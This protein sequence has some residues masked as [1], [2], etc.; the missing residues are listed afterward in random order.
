MYFGV[1]ASSGGHTS[2]EGP[3]AG[4]IFDFREA[5]LPH[6][7]DEV[8]LF[9]AVIL[10]LGLLELVLTGLITLDKYHASRRKED[11]SSRASTIPTEGAPENAR[12][13]QYPQPHPP[14]PTGLVSGLTPGLD[15]E[16][17]P[18]TSSTAGLRS[19]TVSVPLAAGNIEQIHLGGPAS[20]PSPETG[21][22]TLVD[23]ETHATL[24]RPR[25][26]L[27]RL[28][29][30]LLVG[31][32]DLI[33]LF[34]ANESLMT[35]LVGFVAYVLLLQFDDNIAN[36]FRLSIVGF[37]IILLP[38][39]IFNSGLEVNLGYFWRN[40][41]TILLFALVGTL[42]STMVL[43]GL[44][45]LGTLFVPDT[46]LDPYVALVFGAVISAV[47]P[48]AVL[49]VFAH[50]RVNETLYS[51]VFGESLLNDA[52]AIVLFELMLGFAE[53][54]PNVTNVGEGFLLLLIGLVQFVFVAV[55]GTIVGVVFGLLLALVSKYFKL[56]GLSASTTLLV[57]IV[58]E[59]AFLVAF[60]LRMSGIVAIFSFTIIVHRYLLVNLDDNHEMILKFIAVQA[61]SLADSVIFLFLGVELAVL[62]LPE[63]FTRASLSHTG[64]QVSFGFVGWMIFSIQL[65]RG[66]LIPL[67]ASLTNMTRELRITV[68]D[69]ALLVLAGL[70]GGIAVLLSLLIPSDL[71]GA[72]LVR[73]TTQFVTLFT[74]LVQGTLIGPLIKLLH[75]ER[76]QQARLEEAINQRDIRTHSSPDTSDDEREP[77][78]ATHERS[79]GEDLVSPPVL[80]TRDV[81]KLPS[82][83]KFTKEELTTLASLVEELFVYNRIVKD[84]A[85][86]LHRR[87]SQIIRW[88]QRLDLF[89]RTFLTA[90]F[91]GRTL[92]MIA[93]DP[94]DDILAGYTFLPQ[95]APDLAAGE[96]SLA[97]SEVES[98]DM[99]DI[100]PRPDT[101][102]SLRP[103]LGPRSPRRHRVQDAGRSALEIVHPGTFHSR[104]HRAGIRTW[105]GGQAPSLALR[106][107]QAGRLVGAQQHLLTSE[108][109]LL[110][111]MRVAGL[112][113]HVGGRD[114]TDSSLGPHQLKAASGLLRSQRSDIT[115]AQLKSAVGGRL[116][117][118]RS[119]RGLQATS[120]THQAFTSKQFQQFQSRHS[121]LPAGPT[122]MP[123]AS[124]PEVP[125]DLPLPPSP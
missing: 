113:S 121:D 11:S 51:L 10:M 37:E 67:L 84:V 68:R 57:F 78:N 97:G 50:V 92:A 12:N 26:L 98:L 61:A 21:L 94:E 95:G 24:P 71:V 44:A 117:Q 20:G 60:V 27:G 46:E 18:S 3:N 45:L 115:Q 105:V 49:A 110:R 36:I 69:M 76:D 52:I 114:K 39:L 85:V 5:F 116:Q 90:E 14:L 70:R 118:L 89:L 58:A 22:Q 2:G 82:G 102:P 6:A 99:P 62:I 30:S 111:A 123:Q 91:S 31:V 53:H 101:L 79:V 81:G 59:V 38:I 125:P 75:I 108:E 112:P 8:V 96:S 74:I 42:L 104:V 66:V 120:A 88:L 73:A 64:F 122:D 55:G 35:I 80:I 107:Q 106:S 41:G 48:V 13:P 56:G 19:P 33:F 17:D 103:G 54:P 65:A 9:F 7:A 93:L 119:T 29:K 63:S 47:D 15:S 28:G 124:G 109:S 83:M 23:P 34:L 32:G 4:E 72:P 16:V 100:P 1:F 87:P 43:A 86:R 40:L 25:P 77:A